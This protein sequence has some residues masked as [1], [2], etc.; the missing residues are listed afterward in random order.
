MEENGNKFN[1][2]EF[3]GKVLESLKN[4]EEK[5]EDKVDRS[6]FT[7]VKSIVYGLVGI[8]LTGVVGALLASV[9]KAFEVIITNTIK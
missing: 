6:E 9:V 7:P 8:I 5:L 1:Q 2:G 3:Q 4:I